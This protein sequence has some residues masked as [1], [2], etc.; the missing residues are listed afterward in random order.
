MFPLC[1]LISD[2]KTKLSVVSIAI[3][4]GFITFQIQKKVNILPNCPENE[5]N[6]DNYERS[7]SI[8]HAN[9][10]EKTVTIIETTS[11]INPIFWKH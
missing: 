5:N 7:N 2:L 6:D 10:H 1:L 4:K 3:K 11:V 8:E 9:H